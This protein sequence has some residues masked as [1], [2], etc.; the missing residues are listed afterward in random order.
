MLMPLGDGAVMGA[1][2]KTVKKG[3][4]GQ[5]GELKGSFDLTHDAGQ[6][7]ANTERGVFG[8]LEDCP[9]GHCRYYLKKK[10]KA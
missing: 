10:L 5:P 3:S 7:Y 8:V 2:V 1:S 9:E 6:L 4:A